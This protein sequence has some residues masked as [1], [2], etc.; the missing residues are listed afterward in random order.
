MAKSRMTLRAK[1][2]E[3]YLEKIINFFKE[4]EDVLRTNSN[5]ISFPITDEEGNEDFI[6]IV[7]K[8]P[9]G[10]RDGEPYDGYAKAEEYALKIKLK[11]EK[12]KEAKIAKEKKIARDKQIREEKKR[13]REKERAKAKA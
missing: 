9:T 4:S 12:A 1:K 13:I 8:I 2:R 5:E 10:S 11:E 6:Q 7:V 3:E